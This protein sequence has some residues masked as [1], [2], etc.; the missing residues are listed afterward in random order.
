MRQIEVNYQGKIKKIEI[1]K[2]ENALEI[3]DNFDNDDF[4]CINIPHETVPDLI[5]GLISLYPDW[6]K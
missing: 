2:Y 3:G 1:G 5:R 4:D 6:D